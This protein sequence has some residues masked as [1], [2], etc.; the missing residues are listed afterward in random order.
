MLSATEQIEPLLLSGEAF[1]SLRSPSRW[2]RVSARLGGLG[3]VKLTVP[4]PSNYTRA[5]GRHARETAT[6]I[7]GIMTT[8]QKSALKIFWVAPAIFAVLFGFVLSF[9]SSLQGSVIYW[10][11]AGTAFLTTTIFMFWTADRF[12]KRRDRRRTWGALYGISLLLIGAVA[13]CI[14]NWFFFADCT[15]RSCL[16]MPV[17]WICVYGWPIATFCGLLFGGVCRRHAEV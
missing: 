6:A 2:I 4:E 12:V 1:I 10:C 14:P 3:S 17:G 16:L 5:L 13:F 15:F 11:D 7:P 8:N 9:D